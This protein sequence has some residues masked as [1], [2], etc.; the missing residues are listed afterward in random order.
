MPIYLPFSSVVQPLTQA[1]S[2]FSGGQSVTWGWQPF[3]PVV[4]AGWNEALWAVIPVTN[5]AYHELVNFALPSG[6]NSAVIPFAVE[7]V[8]PAL[9]LSGPMIVNTVDAN[10][11]SNLTFTVTNIST[12][13]LAISLSSNLDSGNYKFQGLVTVVK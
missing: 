3:A 7:K 13:L 1:P 6:A 2:Q 4:D 12:S 8:S 5:D 9:L 11:L 10:P